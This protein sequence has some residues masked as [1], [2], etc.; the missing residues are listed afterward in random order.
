MPWMTHMLESADE[1]D[2]YAGH[3]ALTDVLA[4]REVPIPLWGERSPIDALASLL[5]P[6][7]VLV[8]LSRAREAD[9]ELVADRGAV[10]AHCPRSNARLGCGTM[11]LITAD[12][13]GVLIGIGTDSPA[14]AGAL[15]MFAEMRSALELHR[16]TASDSTWPDLARLHRMATLDAAQALGYTELGMIDLGAHADLI[17][18]YVGAVDDPRAGLLLRATPSDVRSVMIEGK[19]RNV[20]D[21]TRLTDAREGVRSTR[22]LLALPTRSALRT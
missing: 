6:E 8:H 9:W 7:S 20:S 19:D 22:Q 14:S 3:G 18:V 13:A 2:F 16:S 5:G 11:D 21:R 10:V 12:R 1:L 15:D 4:A 17:A